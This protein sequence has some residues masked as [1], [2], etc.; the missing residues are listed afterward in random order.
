MKKIA[1]ITAASF[2][3][4]APATAAAP[5]LRQQI[6]QLDRQVVTLTIKQARDERL[7]NTLVNCIY[8]IPVE[9]DPDTGALYLAPQGSP[10]VAWVLLD[11]CNQNPALRRPRIRKGRLNP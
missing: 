8:E 2:A 7:F 10:N 6:N 3:L 9:S 1:A 11:N 5:T 4:V